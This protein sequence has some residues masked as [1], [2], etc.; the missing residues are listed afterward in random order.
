[1]KTVEFDFEF[2]EGADE[3]EDC[4]SETG[5]VDETEADETGGDVAVFEGEDGGCEGHE[6]AYSVC[7]DV[8]PSIDEVKVGIWTEI[9]INPVEIVCSKSFLRAESIVNTQKYRGGTLEL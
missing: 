3:V 6:T 9:S 1:M 7:T 8:D 4:F 2:V 5:C